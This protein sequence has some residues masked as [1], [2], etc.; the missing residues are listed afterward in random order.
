MHLAPA[1]LGSPRA[2]R[3]PALGTAAP[4]DLWRAAVD[5]WEQWPGE[6][7]HR[8][9]PAAALAFARPRLPDGCDLVSSPGP[10]RDLVATVSGEVPPRAASGAMRVPIAAA[11]AAAGVWVTFR[12]TSGEAL[13]LPHHRARPPLPAT[14]GMP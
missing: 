4:G 3:D 8:P 13:D 7:A 9:A 2:A 6:P 11:Q 1:S 14:K 12:R 10:A 5:G